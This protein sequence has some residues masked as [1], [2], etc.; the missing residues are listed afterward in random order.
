MVSTSTSHAPARAPTAAT[1]IL[2]QGPIVAQ[3][4]R[5]AAP[6][7]VLAGF[8]IA[9]SI[10]D[11]HYVGRAGT[12]ALAGLA[13]VFPLVMLMQMTSAGAM[14]GGVSS[15]IARALGAGRHADA[16]NL[17]AHALVIAICMGLLYTVLALVGG[18]PLYRLLSGDLDAYVQACAYSD[19]LFSG[20]V[21]VWL[22]NTLAAISRG[23]GD[24]R[25]PALALIAA[26]VIQIA[27]SRVLTL[28]WGP[29]SAWGIAGTAAAHVAG[30]ALAAS[31]LIGRL[32]RTALWPR[33]ED[34]RIRWLPTAD[35]LRVGGVSALSAVQTI[36][37]A[38]FLTGLVSSFGVA[39]LAGYGVGVRLELLMVPVVFSIGQ[40][41]VVMVGVNVGFGASERARRIAWTG[42]G[43]AGGITLLIGVAA[44]L[45]P[46]AWVGLFSDDR[47][48][49]ASGTLYLRIAGP[50]FVFFG[51][52]MGLYFAS[53]GAAHVVLPVLA[54]TGRLLTVA[55]LGAIA[56]WAGAPLYV[57][58]CVIAAGLIV[59]GGATALGVHRTRW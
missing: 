26:A 41:L 56:S 28:G 49:L 21:V 4:A 42:A 33:G 30:F 37:T 12:A 27:L 29:V 34:W 46:A 38:M 50:C 7:M 5:L 15:A 59:F 58:F 24:T 6:G 52:G 22:G 25:T 51:V 39:A 23:S 3:I 35:I 10:A 40:A 36:V 54:G 13:L 9:T 8:Q 16:R 14:G 19:L 44:A 47:D 48:V 18:P 17:V 11:T 2:L 45:F 43:I 53:Q 31:I 1:Q 20:A 55:G 32:R 57:M